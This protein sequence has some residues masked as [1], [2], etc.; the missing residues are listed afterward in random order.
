MTLQQLKYAIEIAKCGSI[1]IAAK[2]F[3]ITQ[4]SLSNAIRELENESNKT[5]FERTNRGISIT[6]DFLTLYSRVAT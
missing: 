6:V 3:F 5:I 4:P 2:K 1:N